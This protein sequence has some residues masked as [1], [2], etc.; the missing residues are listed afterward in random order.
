[1]ATG[2]QPPAPLPFGV[3]RAPAL[4]AARDDLADGI[5]DL[6]SC[7]VL[8]GA[9][10]LP[11]SGNGPVSRFFDLL[12]NVSDDTCSPLRWMRARGDLLPGCEVDLA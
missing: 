2:S 4:R 11:G 10:A 6:D 9:V 5:S 8:P 7:A 3:R 1:M 12:A